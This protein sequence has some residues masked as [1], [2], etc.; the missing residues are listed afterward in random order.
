MITTRDV[1]LIN[2]NSIYR[3][4]YDK[5][6]TSRQEIYE[7]TGLS[8]PTI[9]NNLKN[10]LDDGLIMIDGNF[11]STGGRKAQIFSINARAR[12]ALA[13][14]ITGSSAAARLI[15]M[16]GEIMSEA[17]L[18]AAFSLD[19]A[20][21]QSIAGLLEKCIDE[22]AADR[23]RLLGVGITI[24]G[25]LSDDNRTIINAPTMNVKKCDIADIAKYIPYPWTAMN[26]AKSGCFAWYWFNRRTLGGDSSKRYIYLSLGE[27]VGGAI[28]DGISGMDGWHNR[29]G[30]FG[31]MTIHPGGRKCF[32]GKNGC[33]ESYVSQRC[34]SD[35]DYLENLAI[36]IN[37]LYTISECDIVIGGSVAEY[38][39]GYEDE[40]KEK[41][42]SRYSF[43]TDAGYVRFSDCQDKEALA[44]AAL[45]YVAGFI[46]EI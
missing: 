17:E 2:K 10:L 4:I 30:E 34:L 44:G 24:P 33:F 13:L 31:H 25:V 1:K 41:L 3:F 18:E 46:D 39:R 38:L 5:G 40:L 27:G 29:S 28:Y 15:D 42:V 20:H 45:A 16:N 23:D 36:G 14:N 35:K 32:C 37:N 9:H 11:D 21:C 22:A 7:G 6:A 19:E 43:D 8:M 26:D 12:F